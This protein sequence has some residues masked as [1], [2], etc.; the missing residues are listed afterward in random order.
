MKKYQIMDQ[1]TGQVYE[2][3]NNYGRALKALD[4]CIEEYGAEKHSFVI[5]ELP[6]VENSEVDY[7]RIDCLINTMIDCME[8]ICE[9]ANLDH[10][11]LSYIITRLNEKGAFMSAWSGEKYG[12]TYIGNRINI[13]K[14]IHNQIKGETAEA[15][16]RYISHDKVAVESVYNQIKEEKHEE[17]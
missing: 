3:T 11:S 9:L 16:K 8:K 13:F 5:V 6:E 4:Y 17:N 15:E 2:H 10:I 14:R 12:T 7:Q 1:I